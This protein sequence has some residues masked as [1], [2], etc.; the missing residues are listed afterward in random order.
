MTARDEVVAALQTVVPSGIEVIAYSRDIDQPAKPTVMVRVDRVRPVP[1]SREVRRY[2]FALILIT[3]KT[4]AG[5]ADDELDGLL[6]DVLHAVE[7]STDGLVWTQ[8]TRA[9]Y[10]DRFPAYQIELDVITQK[11]Q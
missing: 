10:E 3:P 7:S 6:E 5:P 1:E 2:G 11:E 9:N 4:T 8:A